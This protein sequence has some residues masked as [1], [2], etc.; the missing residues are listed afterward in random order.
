MNGARSESNGVDQN[1]LAHRGALGPGSTR[2]DKQGVG[3]K[4]LNITLPE[5]LNW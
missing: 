4:R 5:S 1:S 3:K 2:Y